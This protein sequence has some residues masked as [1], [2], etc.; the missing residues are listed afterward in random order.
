MKLIHIEMLL[1]FLLGLN[2]V[3]R[4]PLC[5]LLLVV[6]CLFRRSFRMSLPSPGC[7]ALLALCSLFHFMLT[8]KNNVDMRFLDQFICPLALFYLGSNVPAKRFDVFRKYAYA[9]AFGSFVHGAANMYINRG[10]DVLALQ[11]RSYNDIFSN[12]INATLQNLYYLMTSAMLFYCVKYEKKRYLY[13][14]G[15]ICALVCIWDSIHNASRTMIVVTMG[16][17]LMAALADAMKRKRAAKVIMKWAICLFAGVVAAGFLFLNNVVGIR[18]AFMS[19]SLG[20]RFASGGSADA[21]ET[22]RWEFAMDIFSLLPSYPMGNIPYSDYAH[23]LWLDVALE[24]GIIPFILYVAFTLSAVLMLIRVYILNR[25]SLQEI[26]FMVSVMAAML[27]SFFTEP[28][29]QGI[30]LLFAFFCFYA[31]RIAMLN[32]R[33]GLLTPDS[34]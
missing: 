12:P 3:N 22:G 14:T 7:L 9:L 19:S 29:M 6:L 10:I 20:Q 1:F 30:P 28:I 11:G 23:N 24:V 32:K 21:M 33:G 13:Y 4:G 16:I 27:L 15:I 31:G 34:L 26:S 17:F 25:T 8:I 2:V 18:D 5:A